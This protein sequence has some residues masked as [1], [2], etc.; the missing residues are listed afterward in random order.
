MSK[1]CQ[2]C[3]SEMADNMNFCPI[4]HAKFEEPAP[5]YAPQPPPAAPIQPPPPGYAGTPYGAQPAAAPGAPTVQYDLPF[6]GKIWQ[7]RMTRKDFWLLSLICWGINIP[8]SFIPIVGQIVSL[9][10]TYF[11]ITIDISRLHD[12]GKSA[13]N[14][15]WFLLPVIGWIILIVYYCQPSEQGPNKYGPESQRIF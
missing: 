10:I 3:G 2:V 13:W 5:A 11:E 1:I 7:K 8:I 6:W 15:L 14:I 4:C 12:A 9:V